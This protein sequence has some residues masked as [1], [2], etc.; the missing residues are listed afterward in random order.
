MQKNTHTYI[1]GQ[2]SFSHKIANYMNSYLYQPGGSTI[3][4]NSIYWA[5]YS[6]LQIFHHFEFFPV[7]FPHTITHLQLCQYFFSSKLCWVLFV[8]FWTCHSL[9]LLHWIVVQVIALTTQSQC[10]FVQL[11]LKCMYLLVHHNNC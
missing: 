3:F 4:M 1:F 2:F 10:L 7:S 6:C 9:S 5:I 8:Y 11:S